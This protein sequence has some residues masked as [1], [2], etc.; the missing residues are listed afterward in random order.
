MVVEVAVAVADAADLL[1]DEI[2]GFGRA[3]GGAAGGVER[4]DLVS[5]GIDGAREPGQLW[6]VESPRDR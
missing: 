5:P 6:D 4:E 3:V 2:H 1:D